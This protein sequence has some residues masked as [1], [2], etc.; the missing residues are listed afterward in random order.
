M[1]ITTSSK[2]TLGGTVVAEAQPSFASDVR[3]YDNESTYVGENTAPRNDYGVRN[4]VLG[5]EAWI[6]GTKGNNN[7][8]AGYR[9]CPSLE[10][11][12]NTVF[13][14]LAASAMELATYNIVVGYNAMSCITSCVGNVA[15]GSYAGRSCMQGDH[16]T[17]VGHC[18]FSSGAHISHA[19]TVLG[20]GCQGSG[21]SNTVM[22]IGNNVVA[23][24][25]I[26]VGTQ[27]TIDGG[28]KDNIMIGSR[29]TNT[30]SGCIVIGHGITNNADNT[31]NIANKITG[32]ATSLNITS[33]T[34][35]LKTTHNSILDLDEYNVHVNA[36]SLFNVKCPAQFKDKV[37][38]YK[39]NVNSTCAFNSNISIRTADK[40]YWKIGLVNKTVSPD[41]TKHGAD[42]AFASVNNTVFTITDDFQPEILNFTGK[43]RCK[44]LG[45]ESDLKVGMIVV[46]TG[47]YCNLDDGNM[48]SI[49][50]SIPVI[51]VSTTSMDP[52]AFGVLCALEPADEPHRTFSIGSIRFNVEK[53]SPR[54]IINSVGEGGIWVCNENG[55]IKNGDLLTT[56]SRPGLA[57]RQSHSTYVNYT[58]AKSTCD[59]LFETDAHAVFIGCTYKF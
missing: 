13:G 19:N 51:A 26:V 57:M 10:G 16:N 42:L 55:P 54:V 14:T 56:S 34:I 18:V 31:I 58:V 5:Y 15:I 32:S 49:D 11:N 52:R 35:S 3:L 23:N 28:G 25:N 36:R 12:N 39:L 8:L 1:S 7:V 40:E 47:E 24:H 21:A 44:F 48:V 30:H 45:C 9:A 6:D 43:H 50:E 38:V 22:G 20:S 37:D 4:T 27:N 2:Y 33:D 17:F 46:A 29:N 53:K 41:G 59:S